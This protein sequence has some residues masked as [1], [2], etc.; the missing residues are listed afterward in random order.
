MD[1]NQMLLIAIIIL[2]S[3][4]VIFLIYFLLNYLLNI[5]REKKIKNIFDPASLV[6]EES[7]MNVLDEKH[8]LDHI[9]I[10]SQDSFV[11]P[12]IKVKMVT[13]EAI[14]KE[15]KVNPFGIDMKDEQKEDPLPSLNS[16]EKHQ[17]R[18]LN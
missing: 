2:G 6:E 9:N 18:F 11:A 12:H 8:N 4:I 5:K 3:I 13:N 14:S 16:D 7:L 10:P 15:Q 1:I 17:N